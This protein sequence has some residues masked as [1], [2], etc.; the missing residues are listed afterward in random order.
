MVAPVGVGVDALASVDALTTKIS[1][2]AWLVACGTNVTKGA[3]A[4]ACENGG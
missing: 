1:T 4:G 3:G 2:G